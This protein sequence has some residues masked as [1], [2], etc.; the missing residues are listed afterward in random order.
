MG[1]I[2]DKITIHT[3]FYHLRNEFEHEHEHYLHEMT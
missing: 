1:K 2:Q 3:R